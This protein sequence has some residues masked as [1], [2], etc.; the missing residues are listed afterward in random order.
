MGKKNL[1]N[2]LIIEALIIFISSSLFWAITVRFLEIYT[3]T[4]YFGLMILSGIF[5]FSFLIAGIIMKEKK[6]KEDIVRKR[7]YHILGTVYIIFAIYIFMMIV[8]VDSPV[9]PPILGSRNINVD[10]Y[11]WPHLLYLMF[12]PELILILNGIG[13]IVNPN[14][15]PLWLVL[16]FFALMFSMSVLQNWFMELNMVYQWF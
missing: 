8:L 12:L 11:G 13:L 9:G 7:K 16:G 4:I 6:G 1:G 2:L 15:A 3:N 5:T 14:N 10:Y